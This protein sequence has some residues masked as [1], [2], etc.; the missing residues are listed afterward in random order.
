MGC[1]GG[2]SGAPPPSQGCAVAR[3]CQKCRAGGRRD[4]DGRR[5]RAEHTA[6]AALK[7]NA[8]ARCPQPLQVPF[9]SCRDRDGMLLL[10]LGV[11]VRDGQ[12]AAARPNRRACWGTLHDGLMK[13]SLAH[14]HHF[15]THTTTQQHVHVVGACQR[16]ILSFLPAADCTSETCA[17]SC[18]AVAAEME[19]AG[20]SREGGEDGDYV[21]PPRP[22][23]VEPEDADVGPQ[24]PAAKKRK[25]RRLPTSYCALSTISS[26]Y[27][28]E[29]A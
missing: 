5:V 10:G 11:P 16:R 28:D 2:L 21:G 20:P 7:A 14:C 13:S 24:P 23:S 8:A 3:F 22:A 12:W 19:E 17:P 4:D 26:A 27:A 29:R 1:G 9:S 6:Q 15:R 18:G 25:V